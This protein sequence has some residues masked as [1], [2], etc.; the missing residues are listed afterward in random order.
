MYCR[1][2]LRRLG[3]EPADAAVDSFLRRCWCWWIP[4]AA[5][6]SVTHR[7]VAYFMPLHIRI[8]ETRPFVEEKNN[9]IEYTPSATVSIVNLPSTIEGK[10]NE[11]KRKSRIENSGDSASLSRF[12]LRRDSNPFVFRIRILNVAERKN[13]ALFRTKA[14]ASYLQ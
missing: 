14:T 2:E 5:M 10:M 6:L 11:S 13:G 3:S 8:Q 1:S 9:R 7:F 12:L 4:F